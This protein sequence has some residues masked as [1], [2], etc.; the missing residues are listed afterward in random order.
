[1]SSHN[2]AQWMKQLAA[3]NIHFYLENRE[4]KCR[5]EKGTMTS[6]VIQAVKLNKSAII[7]LLL[8]EERNSTPD[9]WRLSYAQKPIWLA[10]RFAENSYDYVIPVAIKA[11][12]EL[13]ISVLEQAI[14]NV[15]TA[16]SSLHCYFDMEDGEVWA[17]RANDVNVDIEFVDVSQQTKPDQQ[18][19]EHCARFNRTPFRLTQQL[20]IRVLIVKRADLDHTIQFNF[21][22][23]AV[24]G[25]SIGIFFNML[26]QYYQSIQKQQSVSMTQVAQFYQHVENEQALLELKGIELER[27]WTNRLANIPPVH[28]LPLKTK[29]SPQKGPTKRKH[30]RL[31]RTLSAQ[32]N[33]F[34]QAQNVS[35]FMLLQTSFSWLLSLWSN[36]QDIVMG[37]PVSGRIDQQYHNTIGCFTNALALRAQIDSQECFVDFLQRNRIDLAKDLSHQAYP[38]DS[39]KAA[40]NLPNESLYSPVFQIWFAFQNNDELKFHVEG[41]ELN[42]QDSDIDLMRF[43]LNLYAREVD[44]NIIFDW[45]YLAELFDDKTIDFVSAQFVSLIQQIIAEPDIHIDA[46]EVFTRAEHRSEPV[47]SNNEGPCERLLKVVQAAPG[48]IAIIDGERQLSYRDLWQRTDNLA[49]QLMTMNISGNVALLFPSGNE[50]I[51]AMLAC[52]K[53]G[54]TY[55]PL[56]PYHPKERLSEL[57]H[58]AQCSTLLASECKYDQANSLALNSEQLQVLVGTKGIAS[59]ETQFSV[60]AGDAIAYILFTSGSSG[61]PKGVMQSYRNLAFHGQTYSERLELSACDN[62]LLLAG[63]SFDASVMDI[64][65]TLFSGASLVICDIKNS[66]A[67]TIVRNIE[68]HHVSVYHSTPTVFRYVFEEHPRLFSHIRALVFGGEPVTE[69]DFKLA[70]TRFAPQCLLFNGY[71]PTEC[72]MAAQWV[73]PLKE[74]NIESIATIGTQLPGIKLHIELCQNSNAPRPCRYFEIGELVIESPYVAKGYFNNPQKTE[75]AFEVTTHTVRYHTGDLG[76]FLPNGQIRVVG[77]KDNQAKL[78]GIRIELGEI[79]SCLVTHSSVKE[80]AVAIEGQSESPFLSAFI[81]IQEHEETVADQ[82]RSYL[83]Q[84]LPQYMIPTVY[85]LL[86]EL[87]KTPSG[88]LDRKRLPAVELQPSRVEYVAPANKSELIMCQWWAAV[89]ALEAKA[90]SRFANFFALGG[91]SLKV[92]KLLAI[93]EAQWSISLPIHVFF[94]NPSLAELVHVIDKIRTV[95]ELNSALEGNE[96]VT[97][98]GWL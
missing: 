41:L 71:G 87:P 32:L 57:C 77:R 63:V 35:M 2:L 81:V 34:A 26:T 40:L 33:Q 25:W 8:D 31:D 17:F 82:L 89:L 28:S 20:P 56:D 91:D 39:L 95:S 65:A 70:M 9:K 14:D 4:L 44:G 1:M 15:I 52:I 69:H 83:Q 48:N 3:C 50:V 96:V 47:I 49:A 45:L 13:D 23:I 75:Q 27:Y 19:Q 88:K 62:V 18:T 93:C 46:L 84:R 79:E 7:E 76:L 72:T 58:E 12:G 29:R 64:F 5:A 61:R 60:P 74:L 11:I 30:M 68:A 24:D 42:V 6:E 21:H 51:I 53:A 36:Q 98:E 86:P 22:H 55:V 66:R 59:E 37:T 67:E 90:I 92:L 10:Q 54:L 78:R 38:F 80:A 97:D 94:E 85:T 16:H 73:V 43:E